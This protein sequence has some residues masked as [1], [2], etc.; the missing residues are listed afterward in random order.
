MVGQQKVDT[1]RLL[2]PQPVCASRGCVGAPSQFHCGGPCTV[3]SHY[4]SKRCQRADWCNHAK[5]CT[6]GKWPAPLSKGSY[7]GCSYPHPTRLQR[8]FPVLRRSSVAC[9]ACGRGF[10]TPTCLRSQ[11]SRSHHLTSCPFRQLETGK[12]R[13]FCGCFPLALCR[14]ETVGWP[15][16]VCNF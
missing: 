6:R 5:S 16:S 12:P 2:N 8:R 9:S 10:C 4:C 1:S 15:N 3:G 13:L 7:P 11:K 14:G